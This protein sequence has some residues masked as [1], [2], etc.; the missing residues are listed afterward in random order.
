MKDRK[1]YAVYIMA[2]RSLN[3]YIGITSNL[4]KRV[5]QHKGH[6]FGGF[7]TKYRIERLV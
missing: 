1:T 2:S 3:F 4:C 5:W 7:T 6:V